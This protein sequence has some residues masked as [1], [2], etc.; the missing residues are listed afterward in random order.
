[1]RLQ[2]EAPGPPGGAGGQDGS[3]R[4]PCGRLDFRLRASRPV[5]ANT[6]RFKPPSLVMSSSPRR[7]HGAWA[8]SWK[9][10]IPN[11]R[12]PSSVRLQPRAE[13]HRRGRGCSPHRGAS[14]TVLVGSKALQGRAACGRSCCNVKTATLCRTVQ[15]GPRLGERG[16]VAQHSHTWPGTHAAQRWERSAHSAP[17]DGA[18]PSTASDL[19]KSL[20]MGVRGGGSGAILAERGFNA[21]EQ[22]VCACAHL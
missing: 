3:P 1:M 16:R 22:V 14:V 17:Q 7:P 20:W 19:G 2:A 5:R 15:S 12:G 10:A 9:E 11:R 6:S 18:L 8:R 21:M 13:S 4:Q